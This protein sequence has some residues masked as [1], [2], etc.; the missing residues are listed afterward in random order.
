MSPENEQRVRTKPESEYRSVSLMIKL[1]G[2]EREAL[3]RVSKQQKR[4]VSWLVREGIAWILQKY[5]R[6][7]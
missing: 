1:T 3:A 4:T 7:R 6:N 5:S 2:E